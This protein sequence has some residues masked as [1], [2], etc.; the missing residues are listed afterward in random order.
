MSWANDRNR[1]VNASKISEIAEKKR[2]GV[3]ISRC[4]TVYDVDYG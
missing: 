1:F 4:M 3:V 2:A